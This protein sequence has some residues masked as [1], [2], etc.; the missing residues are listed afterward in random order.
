MARIAGSSNEAPL[1]PA[2]TYKEPVSDNAPFQTKSR[3]VI[4]TFDS[5][6]LSGTP[7]PDGIFVSFELTAAAFS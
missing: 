7:Q 5:R 4:R 6:L 2:L 3:D 1:T